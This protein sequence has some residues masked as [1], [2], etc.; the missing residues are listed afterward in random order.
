MRLSLLLQR[1]LPGRNVK[2]LLKGGDTTVG[3]GK[4]V[5]RGAITS[6]PNVAVE[7]MK[8]EGV[9]METRGEGEEEAIIRGEQGE[10]VAMEEGGTIRATSRTLDTMEEEA[11]MT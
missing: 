1:C 4:E 3:L 6:T 10:E 11:T 8:E 7:D 5:A 9:S 2:T